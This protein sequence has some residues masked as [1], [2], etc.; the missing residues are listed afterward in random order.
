MAA[1]SRSENRFFTIYLKDAYD[2]SLIKDT[3]KAVGSLHRYRL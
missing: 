3:L 2:W 1:L